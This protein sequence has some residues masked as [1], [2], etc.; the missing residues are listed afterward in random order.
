MTSTKTKDIFYLLNKYNGLITIRDKEEILSHIFKC[1][2]EDFYIENIMIDT[3]TEALYDSFV[4]RRLQGEPLQYIVG[5][6]EFMGMDFSVKKGV[7]IPRPETELLVY[8]AVAVIN[9]KSSNRS[10]TV[11]DLCTGSGNIAISLAKLA[12]P[13]HIS[14]IIATDIS[15]DALSVARF[16]SI[17][18]KVNDRIIFYQGDLFKSLPFDKKYK[19][20]IIV[21]N[22]P[23][24]KT[25]EIRYLQKEVRM[26]P[27]IALDGGKD[28]MD[29]Y[30][31]ISQEIGYFLKEG[32]DIF[33][34]LGYGQSDSVK[35]IFA[36]LNPKLCKVFVDFAGIERVLWI[37]L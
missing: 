15:K 21:C 14:K 27:V 13:G 30:R 1:Q 36:L 26:E 7:F 20:D 29:F 37:S 35:K 3:E 33:L 2:R 34:E 24:I 11:L 32:G 5:K 23:Y 4:L 28:G 22:P 10:L 6:T 16:N 18:H 12:R 19:F 8:Q 25:C 17:S 9:E 31:R